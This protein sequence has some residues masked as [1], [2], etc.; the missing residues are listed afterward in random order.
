VRENPPELRKNSRRAFF[1]S[2]FSALFRSRKR[3][4]EPFFA[5]LAFFAPLPDSY[6]NPHFDRAPAGRLLDAGRLAGGRESGL[7]SAN[8]GGRSM[9][10]KDVVISVRVLP[11]GAALRNTRRISSATGSP[12]ASP[13]I[14]CADASAYFHS[15]SAACK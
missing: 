13:Q 2:V 1:F 14:D 12:S 6:R 4:E 8:L 15:A 3:F 7:R 10:A 5:F 11:A 9:P